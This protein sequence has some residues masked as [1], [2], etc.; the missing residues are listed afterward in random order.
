[1][2]ARQR[3]ALP[4]YLG[5]DLPAGEIALA[6]RESAARAVV[7]AAPVLGARELRAQ[8]AKLRAALPPDVRLWV[9]G[10]TRGSRLPAAAR[11]ESLEALE[12]EVELLALETQA[13]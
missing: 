11:L 6:A 1:V 3:G 4:I 2:C 12:R 13:R 8:W 5:P 10:A 9:G 7:V